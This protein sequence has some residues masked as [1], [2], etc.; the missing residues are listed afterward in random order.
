MKHLEFIQNI[1]SRMAGN[2]FYLRGWIITIYIG[3]LAVY[4]Q[5][6]VVNKYYLMFFVLV[7]TII[8]WGYDGYFLSKEKKYRKLYDKVRLQK[9]EPDFSLNVK[10]YDN[11]VE[12]HIL[13]C[14]FSKTLYLF[15]VPLIFSFLLI[16][17]FTF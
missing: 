6:T 16:L 11:D 15:Y 1:I 3:V 5:S 12:T 8:F 2:L 17:Y 9:D 7:A 14:I 13:S 4:L 10:E